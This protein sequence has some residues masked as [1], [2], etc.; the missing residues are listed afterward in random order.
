MTRKAKNGIATGGRSIGRP[1]LKAA[2]RPVQIVREDEAAE[3]GNG[4]LVR[5]VSAFWSGMANR[6][7]GARLIVSQRASIAASF[8]G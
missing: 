5:F 3:I 2:N 6:V 4:D 7:S 8:A 1:V